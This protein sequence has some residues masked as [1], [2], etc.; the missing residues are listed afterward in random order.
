MRFRAWSIIAGAAALGSYLAFVGC[1]KDDKGTNPPPGGAE[2]NSGTLTA[3]QQYV[4]TFAT[5][6]T[7]PYHCTI[8]PAMRDT[9]IVSAGG[10]DSL[11][12]EIQNTGPSGFVL[13][14]G[15][16]TGTL[17]P[18]GYVHWKNLPGQPAHTVTTE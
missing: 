16:T 7:F 1:S 12:V 11:I 15:G 13:F 4:H 18:G 14:G 6:G 8:H 17:K 9:I 3:G 10:V 5:A 2:L